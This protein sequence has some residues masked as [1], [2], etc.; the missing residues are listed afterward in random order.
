[1]K[2]LLVVGILLLFTTN[3]FS[4]GIAQSKKFQDLIG[5]WDI[6]GEQNAGGGLE[7]IDSANISLTYMG[8]KKKVISFTI[9][10]TKSPY[11][12]DF[13]IQDT[14]DVIRVKSLL[15][16]VNDSML[17]WQLFINEER[18]VFFSATKG[19]LFYLKRS[20]TFARSL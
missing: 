20:A 14:A 13:S 3:G 8:E 9:D 16:V 6:I 10:F 2:K 12:F 18:P 19:E 5:R 11:W 1:M 4:Q 15:G 17:K 7:I